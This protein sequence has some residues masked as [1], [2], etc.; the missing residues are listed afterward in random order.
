MI[1]TDPAPVSRAA[2]ACHGAHFGGRRR[3]AVGATVTASFS[4]TDRRG[5]RI[6]L[7]TTLIGSCRSRS[8]EARINDGRSAGQRSCGAQMRFGARGRTAPSPGQIT[9][10]AV[11][12][13]DFE[14]SL[15]D[16]SD[17]KGR[18]FFAQYRLRAPNTM[19]SMTYGALIR[20]DMSILSRKSA[21]N[22][23]IARLRR[24]S[25]WGLLESRPIK[26]GCEG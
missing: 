25:M 3:I 8:E 1:A 26:T 7:S 21:T 16:R 14:K 22:P 4:R 11:W 6:V 24:G 5:M 15:R 23:L 17:E 19:T 18:G 13:R 12:R 10:A 9:K 2:G 20:Q